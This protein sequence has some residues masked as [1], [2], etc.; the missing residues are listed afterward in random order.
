MHS[1]A[2]LSEQVWAS[3]Q[4]RIHQNL[5]PVPQDAAAVKA[6]GDREHRGNMLY[7]ELSNTRDHS[8]LPVPVETSLLPADTQYTVS[9]GQTR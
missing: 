6:E 1:E 7:F 8:N 5:I 4:D 9:S 3:V 2:F